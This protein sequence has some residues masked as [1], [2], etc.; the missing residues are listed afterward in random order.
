M[1]AL[2]ERAQLMAGKTPLFV[3]ASPLRGFRLWVSNI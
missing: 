2:E 3:S 1:M